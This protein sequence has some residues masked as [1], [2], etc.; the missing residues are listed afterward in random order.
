MP[1]QT[2]VLSSRPLHQP[3]PFEYCNR[4][5]LFSRTLTETLFPTL[6]ITR[7]SPT[8][9]IPTLTV[10]AIKPRVLFQGP[11]FAMLEKLKGERFASPPHPEGCIAMATVIVVMHGPTMTT[12]AAAV[13]IK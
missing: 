4:N 10:T 5:L 7:Q 1:P 2:L 6:Q 13:I 8:K 3:E 11:S 9:R 12:A